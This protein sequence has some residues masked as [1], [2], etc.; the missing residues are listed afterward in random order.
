MFRTGFIKDPEG[1][2]RVAFRHVAAAL[3]LVA[4]NVYGCTLAEHVPAQP[5]DQGQTGSCTG[6]AIAYAIVTAFAAS[7]QPLPFVPSPKDLYTGG[8]ELTRGRGPD[9]KLEPLRD[10]GAMPSAVLQFGTTFGIRPMRCLDDRNSDADP[11]TIDEPHDFAELKKDAEFVVVGDYGIYGAPD[12]VGA[13][14]R[15]AITNGFPVCVAVPGG[16]Q[17]WQQ[18]RG[19]VLGATGA[20]NDHYAFLYGYEMQPDGSYVYYGQNSWNG[21][22]EAGKFRA[23]EAAVAEF[24]NVFAMSVRR[25]A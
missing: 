1:H 7:G 16:S 8:R 20:A 13:Q 4:A 17:Q 18:Y 12:E 5:L 2:V 23:N 21:W 9:G 6:H 3:A 22:G 11:L 14:I 10:E 25:A 24:S 15:Q 19:G